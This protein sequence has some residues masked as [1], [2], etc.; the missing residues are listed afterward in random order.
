MSNDNDD[1]IKYIINHLFLPPILPEADETDI[2]CQQALLSHVVESAAAFCEVLD[3]P[4]VDQNVL[5]CWRILHKM[6][7]SMDT[8]RQGAFMDLNE[9]ESAV[10]D[11]QVNGALC[12]C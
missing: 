10:L 3:R 4:G 2:E 12:N 11:M 7:L 9:L 5:R 8:I 6:L 1:I